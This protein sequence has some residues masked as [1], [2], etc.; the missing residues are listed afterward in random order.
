MM[1]LFSFFFTIFCTAAALFAAAPDHPLVFMEEV[2][3]KSDNKAAKMDSFPA[4]VMN[5]IINTRKFDV[6]RSLDDLKKLQKERL[7]ANND[8]GAYLIRMTVIQ[9]SIAERKRTLGNRMELV[10][11]A[12]IVAQL[13]YSEAMTGK[14]LESKRAQASKI[15]RN[16]SS[17]DTVKMTH[18]FRQKVMEEAVQD[19]ADQ[20]ADRFME[21]VY[22]LKMLRISGNSVY[23]NAGQD[24]VKPNELL[25]VYKL[26]EAFV[27]PDT[28]E[29]LGAD[30]E[31]VAR[32]QVVQAKQKYSIA[33]VVD[34]AIRGKRT[35]YI[36]RKASTE[37]IAAPEAENPAVNP[38]DND[39]HGANPF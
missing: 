36:L 15:T 39:P 22:P 3:N 11:E 38:A 12:K 37:Q 13:E 23:I 26:G 8:K 20:C 17:G 18:S 29:N 1:K 30:E 4:A 14:I 24:R 10:Y 6:C 9:Y 32:L 34:G 2:S 27:D 28:G 31:Y 33:S 7:D 19:I 21:M 5:N 16:V 25:N 35:D